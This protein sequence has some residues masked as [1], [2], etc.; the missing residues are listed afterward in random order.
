MNDYRDVFEARGHLYNDAMTRFPHAR[1]RELNA[2]LDR[3]RIGPGMVVVDAPAGGGY[4][5]EGVHARTGGDVRIICVEPSPRFS[6]AIRVPCRIFNESLHETSLPDAS[7]DLVLSLAGLHHVAERQPIYDEWARV[8]R[9]GGTVAVAD[10]A[11]DTPTGEFL[12]TFVDAHVAGGHDG[13]FI[14]ET[15]FRTGLGAAGLAVESDSLESVPWEFP[16][17]VALGAFCREL[18]GVVGVAVEQVA[19][20]LERQVGVTGTPAGVALGWQLR[21]AVARKPG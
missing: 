5:A 8:L 14:G 10:V 9:P 6:A 7:V 18:F 21:Y 1:D 12:N 15:E 3:V 17:M 11:V 20:A 16:D 19:E 4:V 13:I 2:L